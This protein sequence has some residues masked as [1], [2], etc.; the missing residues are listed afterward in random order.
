M[1]P[2]EFIIIWIVSLILAA[3]VNTTIVH[4]WAEMI[5]L[6]KIIAVAFWLLFLGVIFLFPIYYL[7]TIII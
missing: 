1:T 5:A 6:V 7:V 4:Y 2:L 3:I